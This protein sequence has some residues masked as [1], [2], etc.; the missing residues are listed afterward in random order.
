M[1]VKLLKT[2]EAR[3][4]TENLLRLSLAIRLLFILVLATQSPWNWVICAL[5]VSA[6]VAVEV[7]HR[8]IAGQDAK[9]FASLPPQPDVPPPA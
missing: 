9:Q 4:K 5:L 7:W 1:A 2:A 6:W 3:R 8:S